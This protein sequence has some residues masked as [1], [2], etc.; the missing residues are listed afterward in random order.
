ML[1]YVPDQNITKE[2]CV[3]GF[4]WLIGHVPGHFKRQKMCDQA[5]KYD[6]SSLQFVPDWFMAQQQIKILRDDDGFIE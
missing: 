4:P 2:M 5:E 1:K 6:C 3:R